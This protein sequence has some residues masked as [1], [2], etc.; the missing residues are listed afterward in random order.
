MCIKRRK[1]LVRV[2]AFFFLKDGLAGYFQFLMQCNGGGTHNGPMFGARPSVRSEWISPKRDTSCSPS[3]TTLTPWASVNDKGVQVWGDVDSL[4][5]RRERCKSY[6]PQPNH[7]STSWCN[8]VL[9]YMLPSHPNTNTDQF[10]E[11]R[12]RMGCSL[13]KLGWT[14]G[15]D[16]KKQKRNWAN[17]NVNNNKMEAW[18][19]GP[20]LLMGYGVTGSALGEMTLTCHPCNKHVSS[21]WASK[22]KKHHWNKT[23]VASSHLV[24]SYNPV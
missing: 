5:F 12:K 18:C 22:P 19:M 13:Y 21:G 16:G 15:C 9:L 6:F 20:T 8:P 1:G 4:C 11:K 7:L 24:K 2:T 17:N 23:S 10:R 3:R 14:G